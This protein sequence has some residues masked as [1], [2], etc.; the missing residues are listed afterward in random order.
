L[1]V[2]AVEDESVADYDV[3]ILT[4][5]LEHIRLADDFLRGIVQRMRAGSHLIVTVPNGYGVSELLLR[6][7]Y[8]LKTRGKGAKLIK[9]VRRLLRTEELTTANGNTPHV[10]FFTIKRLV[11]LFNIQGLQVQTF[12][13]FFVFGVFMEWA[14]PFPRIRKL[15]TKRDFKLSQK[16]PPALCANW[17]FLIEKLQ[18]PQLKP[19]PDDRLS[20][21]IESQPEKPHRDT[22]PKS[23]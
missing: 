18:V 4:E 16:L 11:N 22:F 10:R 13:R 3:I 14:C 19:V 5:V 17:A 12:A 8:W 2:R 21:G 20:S 23:A 6:P 1:E 7:A 15:G 9:A